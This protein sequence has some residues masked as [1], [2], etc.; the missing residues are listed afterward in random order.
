MLQAQAG[1][2]FWAAVG[3]DFALLLQD[4]LKIQHIAIPPGHVAIPLGYVTTCWRSPP[5]GSHPAWLSSLA[6]PCHVASQTACSASS[7][8]TMRDQGQQREGD[9]G[10]GQPTPSEIYL[11][12]VE[13]EPRSQPPVDP[14]E[15]KVHDSWS[16][17]RGRQEKVG[18][19]AG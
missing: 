14:S 6:L 16:K 13:V 17:A 3:V 4:F 19:L 9:Q 18:W 12:V 10:E 2:Q 11:G 5:K 15:Q 8:Q 7:R 1:S